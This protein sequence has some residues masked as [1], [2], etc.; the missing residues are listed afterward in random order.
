MPEEAEIEA[1]AEAIEPTPEMIKAGLEALCD[2]LGLVPRSTNHFIVEMSSR[3]WSGLRERT[4]V[5][6]RHSPMARLWSCPRAL[7]RPCSARTNAAPK[8]RGRPPVNSRLPSSPP[9]WWTGAGPSPAS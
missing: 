1:V 9:P 6:S 3:R 4:L 2:E 8:G 7:K 5:C